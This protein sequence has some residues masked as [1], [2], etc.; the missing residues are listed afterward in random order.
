MEIARAKCEEWVAGRNQKSSYVHNTLRC[1]LDIALKMVP[2]I[3]KIRTC[4][5]A[6]TIVVNKS[7]QHNTTRHRGTP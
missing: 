1:Q 4:M 7:S 2:S 6:H 3:V 5:E